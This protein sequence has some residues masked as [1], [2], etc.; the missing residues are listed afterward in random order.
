[1]NEVRQA[2][3]AHRPANMNES[4]EYNSNNRNRFNEGRDPNTSFRN[5]GRQ[6]NKEYLDFQR[7]PDTSFRFNHHQRSF[8]RNDLSF[9]MQESKNKRRCYDVPEVDSEM[10]FNQFGAAGRENDERDDFHCDYNYL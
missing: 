6:E 1:M 4:Y 3:P 10:S 8:N 5:E 7:D 2:R 9:Q